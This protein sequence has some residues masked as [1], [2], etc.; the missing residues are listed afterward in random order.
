MISLWP[1][2]KG[3]IYETT[4]GICW[5]QVFS[6]LLQTTKVSI[7]VETSSKVPIWEIYLLCLGFHSTHA[8]LSLLFKHHGSS[9][10]LIFLYVDELVITGNDQG[11]ISYLIQQLSLL[12]EMKHLGHL[13]HF[14]GIEVYRGPQ[15]LFLSQAKYARDLLARVSMLG[16]KPCPSPYNY[17][18]QLSSY[19][20]IPLEDPTLYRSITSLFNTLH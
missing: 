20:S 5:F 17:K 11:Y 6:S 15:G 10:T 9:I 18:K 1:S 8:D 3:H 16:C 7:W 2:S 19:Q 12:F 13:H 14:L 4:S